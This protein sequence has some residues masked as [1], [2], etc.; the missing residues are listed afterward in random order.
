MS[1]IWIIFESIELAQHEVQAAF[2]FQ[3]FTLVDF[4]GVIDSLFDYILFYETTFNMR[5]QVVLVRSP[6]CPVK[7]SMER[8]EE[9]FR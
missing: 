9:S 4:G 3:I 2:V 8:F 7:M 1:G 6:T 5:S